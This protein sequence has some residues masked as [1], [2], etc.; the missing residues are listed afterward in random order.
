MFKGTEIWG[1]RGALAY[2]PENT[3]DS[4]KMAVDMGAVGVELDVQLSK[5]GEVVAIHDEKVDRTTD[6]KGFVKDFS[7]AELKKWQVP[8]LAEV[9]E[10]LSNS[11]IAIN[12]ELKTDIIF[13]AGIEEKALNIAAK[14]GMM[15]RV[16]WSSFNHYSMM[17]IKQLDKSA[18]T[19]LLCGNGVIVTGEQCEAAG[20]AALHP[21]FEQLHCPGLVEDCKKRGIKIRPY[22]I[23]TPEDLQLAFDLQVDAVITNYIDRAYEVKN[24]NNRG[25]QTI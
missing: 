4:F 15:N 1:H 21:S 2:S 25:V 10:L 8:S 17:R 5:D 14:H 20:A 18:E 11:D 19:A 9:F 22:T 24:K 7:F 3:L 23:N 6:G 12:V 13:Y 16:I